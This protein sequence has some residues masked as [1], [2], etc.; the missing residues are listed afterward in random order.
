MS[1]AFRLGAPTGDSSDAT[2]NFTVGRV[3]TPLIF[4]YPVIGIKGVLTIQL[5][6]NPFDRYLYVL[7]SIRNGLVRVDLDRFLAADRFE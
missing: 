2:L 1:I 4:E 6:Y 3:P 5:A 7:E